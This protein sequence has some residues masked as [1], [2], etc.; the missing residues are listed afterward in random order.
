M[1]SYV[2]GLTG[3]G[4]FTVENIDPNFCTHIIYYYAN[5]DSESYKI[6]IRYVDGDIKEKGYEKFAALKKKNPKLKVIISVYL[7]SG[8]DKYWE[9][10]RNNIN[11]DAFVNSTVAFLQQYK[12]DGLDWHWNVAGS[13]VNLLVALKNAFLPHG[14]LLSALGSQ[15]KNEIDKGK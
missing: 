10:V 1:N 15:F 12:F 5:I 14:Y 3:L 6:N 9:L 8:V 13:A 2:M 4:Y 7:F 11:I